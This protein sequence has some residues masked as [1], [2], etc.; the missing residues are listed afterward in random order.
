L[1]YHRITKQTTLLSKHITI[2]DCLK[3]ENSRRKS[4][5][6]KLQKSQIMFHCEPPWPLRLDPHADTGALTPSADWWKM[7]DGGNS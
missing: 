5:I 3:R 6:T 7:G 4:K 1:P 2:L